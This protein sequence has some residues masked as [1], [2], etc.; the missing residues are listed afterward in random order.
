MRYV[1][2]DSHWVCIHSPVNLNMP[3][4]H[5]LATDTLKSSSSRGSGFHEDENAT[6]RSYAMPTLVATRLD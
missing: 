3:A 2:W 6:S 4:D 5:S 1:S